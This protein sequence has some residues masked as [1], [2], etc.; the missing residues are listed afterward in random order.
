M[1]D[2]VG[3]TVVEATRP[4]GK[5]KRGRESALDMVRSLAV[6][7]LLVVPL[8]YFGQAS[9]GDSKRIRPVDP[10]AALQDFVK[11][12]GGPVPSTPSGWTPNVQAYEGG[13]LRVGY[14]EGEHYTEFLGGLG[15]QFVP[16]ATGKGSKVGTVVV[17]GADWDILESADAHES[18][19]RAFGRVTI[20][21][22]GFRETATQHELEVLASTIN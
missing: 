10:S 5:N 9:P 14:V 22:G 2:T 12:T 16:N 3:V 11:A 20:V 13:V 8:W 18:L 21:I 19:V 15:T 4:T 7:F 17:N 6:V 1:T